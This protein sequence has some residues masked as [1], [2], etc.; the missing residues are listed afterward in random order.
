MLF[1]VG[2]WLF[3]VAAVSTLFVGSHHLR[4]SPL[5]ACLLLFVVGVA[6]VVLLL[7][8]LLLSSFFVVLVVDVEVVYVAVVCVVA[9]VVYRNGIVAGLL[10]SSFLL[11]CCR[12]FAVLYL[13]PSLAAWIDRNSINGGKLFFFETAS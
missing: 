7:F 3:F 5:F 1:L 4:S 2:S 11:R 13:L 6:V 12:V 10:L 8:F 9:V